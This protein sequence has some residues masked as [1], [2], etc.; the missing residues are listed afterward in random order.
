LTSSAHFSLR[1]ALVSL[2]GAAVLMAGLFTSQTAGAAEPIKGSMVAYNTALEK[3]KCNA[4]KA[5]TKNHQVLATMFK[6]L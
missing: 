1:L 6:G 5:K 2:T 3:K 4:K